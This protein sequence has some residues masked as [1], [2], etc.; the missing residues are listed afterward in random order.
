M[1]TDW[2]N[3]DYLDSENISRLQESFL[4]VGP[5]PHLELKDFFKEEKIIEVLHALTEEKFFLKDSDLFTFLQTNDFS[6]TDN[7]VLQEFRTFLSSKKF[8]EYMTDLTRIPLSENSFDMFGTSYED[9]HYLLPHDDR[10]EGRKIAYFCYLSNLSRGDGGSLR[11]YESAGVAKEIIPQFNT[12]AFFAVSRKSFH[13]VK[14][15]VGSQ[16][17]TITGWFHDQ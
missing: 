4:S 13:E 17:I 10:L 5:F 11:L 14:E 16:R 8:V 9:K 6:S 2:V 12:F 15:V 7:K 3:S 1:L